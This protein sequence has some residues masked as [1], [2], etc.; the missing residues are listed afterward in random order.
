M[1]FRDRVV[2]VTGGTLGIGLAAAEAFAREG[3]TLV[4]I[5]RDPVQGEA[6]AAGI[7]AT[8]AAPALFLPA[9]VADPPAVERA[10][11]TLGARH[12]RLDVLVNC[13]GIYAQAGVAETDA[14][15]W[16]RIMAVNLDGAFLCLRA[17]VPLMRAGGAVVNVAS[18]AGLVGI[19]GQAAYN[20][21]KAGLIGLTRSA[22]VDLA[23]RGIRVNCVCPGTTETPLVA[24]A[25][26]RAPDPAAARRALEASRPLGRLGTAAESAA[27]ILHLAADEAGYTTGAVLAVDG[28]S[29]AW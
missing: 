14:A 21:S 13:A 12:G 4:L 8:A 24:A 19:A 9:D 3:A 26:A 10:F 7:S 1:R 27:A 2:L 18:E 25:L 23:P 16:R 28:G 20:T 5:G 17:A 15:T 11:A 6:A 29:T 22:A